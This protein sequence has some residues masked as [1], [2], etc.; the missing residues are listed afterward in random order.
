MLLTS[1]KPLFSHSWP[2]EKERKSF[3]DSHEKPINFFAARPVNQIVTRS[4]FFVT[5]QQF[6]C[7]SSRE[8]EANP[9]YLHSMFVLTSKKAR[10]TFFFRT[11]EVKTWMLLC[12]MGENSLSC[13]WYPKNQLSV[14]RS[15]SDEK[16][17]L[18]G[19]WMRRYEKL[20]RVFPSDMPKLS[21][22]RT[23]WYCL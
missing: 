13:H 11:V 6:A 20:L 8:G 1:N 12:L 18:I 17:I 14:F 22:P 9:L 2:D 21:W 7:F 23:R 19:W 16:G 3:S 5:D 10:N 15:W 4:P